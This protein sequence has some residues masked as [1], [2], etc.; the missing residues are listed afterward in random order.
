[1]VVVGTGRYRSTNHTLS[2][3]GRGFKANVC[4]VSWKM[5]APACPVSMATPTRDSG[6]SEKLL[7]QG[8]GELSLGKKVSKSKCDSCYA[9]WNY[10]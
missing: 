7:Q 4:L 3:N 8:L 6:E 9:G 2:V 10:V 5:R 1:M